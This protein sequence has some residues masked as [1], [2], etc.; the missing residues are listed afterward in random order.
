VGVLTYLGAK[1]PEGRER[2]PPVGGPSGE[3]PGRARCFLC[4]ASEATIY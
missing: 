2:H 4:R 1:S 3:R